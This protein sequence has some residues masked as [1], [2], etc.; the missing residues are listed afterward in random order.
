MKQIKNQSKL[1]RTADKITKPLGRAAYLTQR[2]AVEPVVTPIAKLDARTERLTEKAIQTASGKVEQQLQQTDTGQAAVVAAKVTAAI[3]KDHHQYRKS[4]REYEDSKKPAVNLNKYSRE[5]QAKR[6][7]AEASIKTQTASLNTMIRNYNAEKA[8]YRAAQQKLK[9]QYNSGSINKSQYQTAAQR[10]NTKYAASLNH[11]KEQIAREKLKLQMQSKAEA[12]KYKLFR[13]ES[14]IGFKNMYAKKPSQAHL[15]H[16]QKKRQTAF[17][18][19]RKLH[20]TAKLSLRKPPTAKKPVKRIQKLHRQHDQSRLYRKT[21]YSLRKVNRTDK[22]LFREQQKLRRYSKPKHQ[23]GENIASSLKSSLR[24]KAAE[25]ADDDEGVQAA[26]KVTELAGKVKQTRRQKLQ[27]AKKRTKKLNKKAGIQSEKLHRRESQ[28]R[29][30]SLANAKNKKPPRKHRTLKQAVQDVKK[31]IADGFMSCAAKMAVPLIFTGFI[32]FACVGPVASVLTVFESS[33]FL[34]GTY[35][36]LDKDL[37]EAEEY[38]TK[39]LYDTNAAIVQCG[40]RNHWRNGLRHFGVDPDGYSRRPE[41]FTNRSGAVDYDIWKIWSFLCAYL[42]DY[43]EDAHEMKM[44]KF[45]NAAKDALKELFNSQ[46]A[47]EHT[48][49]GGEHYSYDATAPRLPDYGPMGYLGKATIGIAGGWHHGLLT[50]ENLPDE[51]KGFADYH[52]LENDAGETYYEYWLHYNLEN[53]EILNVG[54]DTPEWACATGWYVI[55]EPEWEADRLCQYQHQWVIT[56]ERELEYGMVQVRSLDDAIRHL[57]NDEMYQYYQVLTGGTTT[58]SGT[59]IQLYGGHQAI[60][61]PTPG[62][63][64]EIMLSNGIM[65]GYG[66]TTY[67]WGTMHCGL[68]TDARMHDGIDISATPGTPVY[69]MFT[70]KITDIGNGKI[71]LSAADRE[72]EV[73]FW[74]ERDDTTKVRA[75]YENITPVAGLSEGDV[76][77]A[78]QQIGTVT[79]ARRCD[80]HETNAP[81]Y[82]LHIQTDIKNSTFT[83]KT[84][85]PSLLIG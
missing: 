85:D 18:K 61:K 33:T 58:E 27:S 8:K 72:Y 20:Q 23:W 73:H 4:K 45:N 63:F 80:G 14:N 6:K 47:F 22:R 41:V 49:F 71:K 2:Y 30:T 7:A 75:T 48:Y 15:K 76:V 65:H 34:L 24:S 9:A 51:I 11:Q 83:W 38:Y 25:N 68:E 39:L 74:I 54:P 50:F 13:F 57:L 10:L 17:E 28:L 66:Y 40:S 60:S 42:Y 64:R 26:L 29:R 62:E 56:S 55:L 53:G 32:C 21:K 70:G 5:S 16:I 46:Y 12:W 82:Y 69:A 1:R 19:D 52:A 31:I 77:E 44:W 67:E 36:V 3:I 81:Y 43:D 37:S 59:P 35:N 84:V 79:D 78:G